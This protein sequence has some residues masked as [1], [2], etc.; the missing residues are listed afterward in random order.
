MLLFVEGIKYPSVA[1]GSK[2]FDQVAVK[3]SKTHGFMCEMGITSTFDFKRKIR[4]S[5][6]GE[7]GNMGVFLLYNEIV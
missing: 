6:R 1:F 2:V 3:T 4:I 5:P 7:F